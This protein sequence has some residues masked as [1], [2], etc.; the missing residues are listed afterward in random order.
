MT[1]KR[2][3]INQELLKTVLFSS[4]IWGLLAHSMVLFNKYSFHDDSYHFNDVG[5]TYES[6]RWM[7]GIL[8]SCTKLFF[9]SKNYSLPVING[10]ITILFIAMIVYILLDSLKIQSKKMAVLICG[11]MVTFPAITG[12][13]GFMFTAPYYYFGALMTV[14][15]AW[16][17]HQKKSIS[18]ALICATLMAC[19]TGIYQANISICICSLLLYMIEDT[20]DSSGEWKTFWKA[21][22][23]NIAV[24]LGFITEYFLINRIFLKILNVTLTDYQGIN[25]FGKTGFLN[26]IYRVLCG[27]GSFFYPSTAVVAFSARWFYILWLITAL[28]IA[29]IALWKMYCKN[30]RKKMLQLI[31]T[32]A[33]FPMASCFVYLMVEPWDV[34]SLMTFGQTFPFV[35]SAWLITE[36]LGDGTL[37]KC[38]RGAASFFMCAFVLLN[39]RY[40]NICYLEADI[41]QA[42]VI[43]YYNVLISR[44]QSTEGYTDDMEIIYIGEYDKD[45]KSVDV[46]DNFDWLDT[47]PYKQLTSVI[48]DY[49]WKETMKLWCGFD[50]ELGDAEKFENDERVVA[51][52]CYP[53]A[54]SIR[55]MDGKIIV[56]FADT[57][58]T[59]R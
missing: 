34:H 50:Q 22:F 12:L 36:P 45:I 35:L 46:K 51:M 28:L 39:V 9:G 32:F 31:L 30:E 3:N 7:L 44:I 47:V 43:S 56:K 25:T 11:V 27:Y 54:G 38:L 58:D 17:F 53:N 14:V 2:L 18:S 24:C 23:S 20:Y 52:P 49:S 16:L 4:A 13:F 37:E 10:A 29:G 42:H 40:A 48:N 8:G 59:E 55:C 21:A 1:E 26:F 6:G 19:S 57:Q 41:L 15:G 33:A 5:A